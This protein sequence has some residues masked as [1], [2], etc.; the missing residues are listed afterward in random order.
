[1][2]GDEV[3]VW[4]PA[5]RL[6]AADIA[7]RFFLKH[8]TKVEIAKQLG[9][10]R[11]QVARWLDG[12]LA[13]GLV[14]IDVTAGDNLDHTASEALRRAYGLRRAF[15]T[16]P[17]AG[18]TVA[19]VAAELLS[20]IVGADEILGLA[21]SRTVNDVVGALDHLSPCTVVQLCGT[22]ALPWRQDTSAETVSRAGAVCGGRTF[23]IYAPL[24]LPDHRTTTAM[25]AQPG[26]AEALRMFPGLTKAVVSIGA[27]KPKHS[28][29]HDLLP[30]QERRALTDQGTTAEL[31]GLLLDADGRILDTE[32]STRVLA[33]DADTL[34]AVPEVIALVREP[35]RASAARAALRSGLVT[36][37]VTDICTANAMM[38]L[39]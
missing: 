35:E 36:T 9:L 28:T 24:V 38:R 22:Y 11:F 26:V 20:E 32:L 37:I 10:S 25:R 17:R 18:A 1:M 7:D 4:G 13:R 14:H 6:Q 12:A 33:I 39:S 30:E 21:W 2:S 8:Q 29:V 23:P 34:R 3:G 16:T 15:V 5:R 19:S 27:W 31:V